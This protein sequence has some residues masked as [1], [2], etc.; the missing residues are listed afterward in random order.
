LERPARPGHSRT[1]RSI[2]GS[3]RYSPAMTVGGR[4]L[5]IPDHRL[6]ASG[7]SEFPCDSEPVLIVERYGAS[8]VLAG[9]RLLG[10]GGRSAEIHLLDVTD[11]P[12]VLIAATRSGRSVSESMS[13]PVPKVTPRSLTP[14]SMSIDS[15]T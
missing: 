5:S 15:G 1:A 6:F 10:R 13:P 12:F 9:Q 8:T 4:D 3:R 7:D 14:A 2:P 11:S